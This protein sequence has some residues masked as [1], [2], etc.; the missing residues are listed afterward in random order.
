MK[1]EVTLVVLLQNKAM[2]VI[3]VGLR[4]C[5]EQQILAVTGY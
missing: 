5:V 4:G 1:K 3:C 2:F